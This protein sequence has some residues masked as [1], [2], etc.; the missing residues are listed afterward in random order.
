MGR[1]EKGNNFT[2]MVEDCTNTVPL[3]DRIC[4]QQISKEI[5]YLNNSVDNET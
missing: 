3:V 1:M 4:R 2:I 5:E